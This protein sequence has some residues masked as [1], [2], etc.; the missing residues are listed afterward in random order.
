MFKKSFYKET[1][2]N[3]VEEIKEDLVRLVLTHLPH[4][5]L[6]K[7]R[8]DDLWEFI[9]IKLNNRLL[10]DALNETLS[11]KFSKVDEL[12]TLNGPFIKTLYDK[13][14][15]D[16]KKRLVFKVNNNTSPLI[17]FN[18]GSNRTMD[19]FDEPVEKM[20]CKLYD[21]ESQSIELLS[22]ISLENLEETY[23]TELTPDFEDSSKYHENDKAAKKRLS[24]DTEKDDIYKQQLQK[25]VASVMKLEAE[26][27]RLLALNQQLLEDMGSTR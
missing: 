1:Q 19:L 3:I 23:R 12:P 25:Q 2:E 26:N 17:E 24:I 27:K 11:S 21:M 7:V 22:K 18:Y 9:A 15:K 16:F 5:Q 14:F 8:Q 13:L 4:L 10:K 20:L 6:S